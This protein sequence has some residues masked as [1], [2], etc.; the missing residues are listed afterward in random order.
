MEVGR[1][2]GLSID[3]E[4]FDALLVRRDRQDVRDERIEAA[5]IFGI[6]VADALSRLLASMKSAID[7]S[8]NDNMV[9]T[10]LYN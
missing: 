6:A 9:L 3:D 4:L 8:G 5:E 1:I 2:N 7:V 10:I